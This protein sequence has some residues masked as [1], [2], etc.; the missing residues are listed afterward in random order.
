MGSL[1]IHV[2]F[3]YPNIFSFNISSAIVEYSLKHLQ[4]FKGSVIVLLDTCISRYIIVFLFSNNFFDPFPYLDVEWSSWILQSTYRWS[5]SK[6]PS[7]RSIHVP[8]KHLLLNV[9]KLLN[10]LY[11][12]Y[13]VNI[14]SDFYLYIYWI[15]S[16]QWIVMYFLYNRIIAWYVKSRKKLYLWTYV[17][18][19]MAAAIWQ[20]WKINENNFQS[21]CN[22]LVALF[23]EEKDAGAVFFHCESWYAEAMMKW[24]MS[25]IKSLL[26]VQKTTCGDMY[27]I[28]S[29][30]KSPPD[31][32]IVELS[33][34]S[35]INV[36][37]CRTL[38]C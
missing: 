34:I 25:V 32:M 23:Y 27:L 5:V 36:L 30:F 37:V 7:T 4:I 28:E 9:F 17:I 11:I 16:I 6:Y 24:T 13:P 38:L 22:L 21:M 3:Y 35:R 2:M 10:E 31:A 20:L 19:P 26:S 15:F 8:C 14:F 33:I 12:F 29:G 1:E 18:L